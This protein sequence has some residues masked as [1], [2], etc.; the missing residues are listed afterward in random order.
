MDQAPIF[1]D[2]SGRRRRRF[3]F[4]VAAFALLLVLAAGIFTLSIVE[5]ARAPLLPIE[6]EHPALRSLPPPHEALLPRAQRGLRRYVRL[7]TGAPP[8][9]LADDVPLAI[10]FHAPWD[11]S[12]ASSLRR[13]IGDLDWLIPGWLSVTGADHRLTEFRDTAGRAVINQA[14]HRPLLLPMVQNAIEG[15]WDA[16]GI[17]TLLHAPARRK[18]MLL[19]LVRLGADRVHQLMDPLTGNDL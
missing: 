5:V 9:G 1:Y 15:N 16:P 7:L 18:A 19:K 10:G 17:A 3:A 11:E 12:S 6:P 13:H 2:A 8:R 14:A 4:A